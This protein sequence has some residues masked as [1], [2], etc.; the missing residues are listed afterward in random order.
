MWQERERW[1]DK[2]DEGEKESRMDEVKMKIHVY[3]QNE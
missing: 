3:R 2:K 1:I